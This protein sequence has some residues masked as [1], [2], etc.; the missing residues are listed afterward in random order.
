MQKLIQEFEKDVNHFY[1]SNSGLYPLATSKDITVSIMIY[2]L[3]N[4]IESIEFDSFDRE[5]VKE[6]II[7]VIKLKK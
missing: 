7:E 5:N 4:N 1:N 2:F 6:I 3:R